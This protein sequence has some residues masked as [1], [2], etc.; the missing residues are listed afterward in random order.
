MYTIDDEH[1]DTLEK[2][3]VERSF[4]EKLQPIKGKIYKA[5]E[6]TAALNDV[7]GPDWQRLLLTQQLVNKNMTLFKRI[8]GEVDGYY[9]NGYLGQ[10]LVIVPRSKTVA[11]RQVKQSNDYDPR[12]DAFDDFIS[13]VMQFG[14]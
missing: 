4:F 12:T 7:L 9:A 2:V 3:G 13:L 14:I 5:G 6:R 11:V 1:L 8:M 10:F